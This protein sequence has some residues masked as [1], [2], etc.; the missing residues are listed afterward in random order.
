M[1]RKGNGQLETWDERQKRLA[2]NMENAVQ[3]VLWKQYPGLI[4][5][6]FGF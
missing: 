6:D 3:Q 2:H 4:H 1:Y 5:F